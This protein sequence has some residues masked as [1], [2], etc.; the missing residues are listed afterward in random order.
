MKLLNG[1]IGDFWQKRDRYKGQTCYV[2]GDGPSVKWFDFQ[3]LTDKAVVCCNMFP[4]HRQF[5]E[6]NVVA[7]AL[8]TPLYF[9]HRIFRSRRDYLMKGQQISRRYRQL[10]KAHPRTDFVFNVSNLPF[11]HGRNVNF[12]GKSAD[13]SEPD[14]RTFDWFTGGFYSALGLA[15]YLGFSKMHLIGFDAWTLSPAHE[16]HWYE[17]GVSEKVNESNPLSA[18]VDWLG[19]YADLS[20]IGVSQSGKCLPVLPYEELVGCA[21]VYRENHELLSPEL[22][23]VLAT[24]PDYKIW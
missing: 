19:Q 24:Y 11:I 20:V 9:S 7:C 3:H 4:M 23:H 12:V 16:G 8:V 15:L 18:H 14:L 21:P 22:M 2:I 10:V 1:Q 5:D 17:R 13:F 6:L